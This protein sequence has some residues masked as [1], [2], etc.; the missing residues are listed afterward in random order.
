MY[1]QIERNLT[2]KE[3]RF[4][5]ARVRA[6]EKK[7]RSRFQI[8]R[9]QCFIGF[10][11]AGIICLLGKFLSEDTPPIWFFMLIF[12]GA[13][14]F[15]SALLVKNAL[16]DNRAVSQ[17]FSYY[18]DALKHGRA[19]VERIQSHRMIEIEELEDEGACYSFEIDNQQLFQLSGQEYY[20]G[21]QFPSTDFS[22]IDILDSHGNPVASFFEK[23][24][25]KLEPCKII[26]AT[27]KI[28]NL[29][30]Y[31]QKFIDCSIDGFEKDIKKHYS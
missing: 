24:G 3:S 10:G 13:G 4:L 16:R 29:I 2:E 31:D 26:S 22:L 27:D 20:S 21:A 8:V 7:Y 23:N 14:A 25:T 1:R 6:D 11:I 19:R 12:W 30:P 28:K 17:T 5:K 15:L 18:R 9:N